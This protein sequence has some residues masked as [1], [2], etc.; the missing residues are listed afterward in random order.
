MMDLLE[1]ELTAL[2]EGMDDG[3]RSPWATAA[4]AALSD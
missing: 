2:D 1:V 4:A 3:F